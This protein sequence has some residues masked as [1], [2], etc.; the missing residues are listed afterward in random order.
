[1][2]L[3]EKITLVWEACFGVTFF[4]VSCE[5]VGELTNIKNYLRDISIY[6]IDGDP[7]NRSYSYWSF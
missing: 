1:M 2:S 6:G 5:V 3:F 7:N 4:V